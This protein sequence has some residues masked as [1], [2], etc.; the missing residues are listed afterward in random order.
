MTYQLPSLKTYL[1]G[2]LALT[3]I[4][5]AASTVLPVF[6]VENKDIYFAI[7][8]SLLIG[9]LV[10]TTLDASS[11]QEKPAKSKPATGGVKTIYVGNLSFNTSKHD[12][13]NLFKQY[14]Y[15]H[16]SRVMFDRVTRKSRGFGFVEMNADAAEAAIRELDGMDFSGRSIR[17]NEATNQTPQMRQY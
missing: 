3:I 9:H 12:L 17:V 2:L 4:A 5:L 14:G 15:V 1:I 16:S 8:A 10:G 6:G 7:I 11:A 13:Y